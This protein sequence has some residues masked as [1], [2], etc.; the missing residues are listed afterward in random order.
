MVAMSIKSTFIHIQVDSVNNKATDALLYSIVCVCRRGGGGG[1]GGG[2]GVGGGVKSNKGFISI[3]LHRCKMNVPSA[4]YF[5]Q[6][7][8]MYLFSR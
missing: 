3:L 5:W 6:S 8:G 7:V 1:G 4:L 2:G